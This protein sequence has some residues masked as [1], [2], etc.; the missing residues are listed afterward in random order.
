MK[1]WRAPNTSNPS[2]TLLILYARTVISRSDGMRTMDAAAGDSPAVWNGGFG[3][4][5]AALPLITGF[6]GAWLKGRF[7]PLSC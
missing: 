1:S 3:L 6:L 2:V 5:T 4:V 7:G